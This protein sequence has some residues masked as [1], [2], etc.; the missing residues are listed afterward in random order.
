MTEKARRGHSEEPVKHLYFT[1]ADRRIVAGVVEM[2][3]RIEGVTVSQLM[4]RYVREG[5]QRDSRASALLRVASSVVQP[6][7]KKE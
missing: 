4:E 2:M 6:E 1:G 3:G 7:A 5:L